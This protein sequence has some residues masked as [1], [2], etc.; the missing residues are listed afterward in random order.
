MFVGIYTK[1]FWRRALERAVKSAAQ[2]FVLAVTATKALTA[3]GSELPQVSAWGVD[4]TLVAGLVVG[5]FLLSLATS[6]GS[7]PFGPSDDPSVVR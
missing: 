3:A 6:L 4:W 2:S 1:A 7:E 5:A